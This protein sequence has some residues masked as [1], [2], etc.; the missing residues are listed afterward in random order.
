MMEKNGNT[1]APGDK[2]AFA[3]NGEK[4]A[5]SREGKVVTVD[6]AQEIVLV[7][8]ADGTQAWTPFSQV[9]RE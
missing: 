5:G 9:I 3:T 2:V 4:L 6:P 1:L 8:W 7:K